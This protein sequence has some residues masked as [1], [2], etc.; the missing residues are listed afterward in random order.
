MKRYLIMFIALV[1]LIAMGSPVMADGVSGAFGPGN[2][3]AGRDSEIPGSSQP[4]CLGDVINDL[5]RQG[6]INGAG[7]DPTGIISGVFSLAAVVDFFDV[8]T[9]SDFEE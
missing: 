2:S 5:A 1:S 7:G 3:A 9:C 4:N 6:L 8:E